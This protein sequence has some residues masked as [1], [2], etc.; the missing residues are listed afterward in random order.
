MSAPLDGKA[1]KEDKKPK[2]AQLQWGKVRGLAAIA[3]AQH[4]DEL[5]AQ[6]NHRSRVHQKL[7]QDFGALRTGNVQLEARIAEL[8]GK[9]AAQ[10]EDDLHRRCAHLDTQVARLKREKEDLS[11]RLEATKP[12][13]QA[14]AELQK[15]LGILEHEHGKLQAAHEERGVAYKALEGEHALLQRHHSDMTAD[16]AKESEAKCTLLRK[17][18]QLASAHESLLRQSQGTRDDLEAELAQQNASAERRMDAA[19]AEAKRAQQRAVELG[20]ALERA[21]AEAAS[22]A[23]DRAEKARRL[24]QVSAKWW[25]DWCM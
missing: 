23:A 19:V 18:D 25:R 21:Q 1:P 4:G 10:S 3:K 24:E 2:K 5:E 11:S 16:L 14:H 22:A 8:E 12:D 6:L 7:V 13:E 15:R 9:L 20:A 17:C